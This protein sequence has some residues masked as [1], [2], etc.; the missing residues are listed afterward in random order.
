[1][2]LIEMWLDHKAKDPNNPWRARVNGKMLVRKEYV[3]TSSMTFSNGAITFTNTE[4]E[5]SVS[6]EF[7]SMEDAR[8]AIDQ[9]LLQEQLDRSIKDKLNKLLKK[10]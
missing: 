2:N 6:C 7:A 10:K 8:L 5:Q 3:P 9:Q 1:M 4:E